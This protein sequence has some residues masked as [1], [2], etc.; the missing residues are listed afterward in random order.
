MFNFSL[1]GSDKSRGGTANVVIQEE[2]ETID[3][4]KDK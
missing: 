4:D 3:S 2:H 1:L